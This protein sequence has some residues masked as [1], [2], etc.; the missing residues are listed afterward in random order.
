[1]EE[2]TQCDSL[3]VKGVCGTMVMKVFGNERSNSRNRKTSECY[4]CKQIRH[5]K[6]VCIN[7][8]QGSSIS[9]NMVQ[10]SDYGSEVDIVCFIQQVHECILDS[11]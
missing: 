10:T 5:W 6:K 2:I 11:G 1:M 8:K 7:K 4:S 9:V 3:Y